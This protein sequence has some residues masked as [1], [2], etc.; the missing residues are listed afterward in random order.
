MLRKLEEANDE[1]SKKE[2][3]ANTVL[4]A[5]NE[6]KLASTDSRNKSTAN[7]LSSVASDASMLKD[8]IANDYVNRLERMLGTE[9]GISDK[10]AGVYE[11]KSDQWGKGM[12][13]AFDFA[14]NSAK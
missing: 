13:K 8:S 3:A 12:Q 10:I 14:F 4:G 1:S 7:F 11:N 9:L 5:S 2:M 6:A